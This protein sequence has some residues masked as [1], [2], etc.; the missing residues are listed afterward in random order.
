MSSWHWP[1]AAARARSTLCRTRA[2]GPSPRAARSR[3]PAYARHRPTVVHGV[4]T[5]WF[6]GTKRALFRAST[7]RTASA[8]SAASAASVA[9]AKLVGSARSAS[10]ETGVNQKETSDLA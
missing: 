6:F 9:A 8:A 10:F 1:P 7:G 3:T 4:A 5:S 2:R